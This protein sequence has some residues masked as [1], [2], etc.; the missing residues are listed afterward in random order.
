MHAF[1]HGVSLNGKGGNTDLI[2]KLGG[3]LCVA[4]GIN[5][6]WMAKHW[7]IME[8]K[9]LSARNIRGTICYVWWCIFIFS[10][11]INI[12]HVEFLSHEHAVDVRGLC[13]CISS[14]EDGV[15]GGV[16][17]IAG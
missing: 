3:I 2:Y 13:V 15:C 5:N 10:R 1:R 7:S 12:R 11:I 17:H 4:I 16:L 14:M 6:I 9:Y 8:G